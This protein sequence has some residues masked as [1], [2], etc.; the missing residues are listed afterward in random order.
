MRT[1][2]VNSATYQQGGPFEPRTR[3]G[4]CI[5]RPLAYLAR[6]ARRSP[7]SP[8]V[9]LSLTALGANRLLVSWYVTIK[10][11]IDRRL[12][13]VHSRTVRLVMRINHDGS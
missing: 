5:E 11:A 2:V 12:D 8:D 13:I 7:Q 10:S 9:P 3:S 1:G 4:A 6:P